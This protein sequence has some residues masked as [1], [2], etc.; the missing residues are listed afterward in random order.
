MSLV[1]VEYLRDGNKATEI[2]T[3]ITNGNSVQI[4]G[5]ILLEDHFGLWY[6]DKEDLISMEPATKAERSRHVWCT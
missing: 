4:P 2:C 5:K 1:K 3:L 6:L